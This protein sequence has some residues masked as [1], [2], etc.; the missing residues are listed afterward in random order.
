MILQGFILGLA[1]GSMMAGSPQRPEQQMLGQIPLRCLGLFETS[2]R[3]YRECRGP[4][5]RPEVNKQYEQYC[6]DNSDNGWPSGTKRCLNQKL[7]QNLDWEVAALSQLVE[8]EKKR[9]REK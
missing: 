8:I 4:T 9:S 6:T 5:L 3:E 2:V 7:E 1:I